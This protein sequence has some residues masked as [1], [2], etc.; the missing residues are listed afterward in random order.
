MAS[1]D[2][3]PEIEMD[4]DLDIELELES[5]LELDASPQ[6]PMTPIFFCNHCAR[7]QRLGAR[8]GAGTADATGRIFCTFECA[9]MALFIDEHSG[10][11]HDSN[12][13]NYDYN[14]NYN[15]NPDAAKRRAARNKKKASEKK[16]KI[17]P[18]ATQLSQQPKD[19]HWDAMVG[20]AALLGEWE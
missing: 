12:N 16:S 15:Y 11:I 20:M 2:T 9:W 8:W 10:G 5:E 17:K 4:F 13:H 18:I 14:Y 19:D 7:T 3:D 1:P 6:T